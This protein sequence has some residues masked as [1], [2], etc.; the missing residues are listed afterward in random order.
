MSQYYISLSLFVILLCFFL[1]LNSLSTFEPVKM[2]NV[3]SSVQF[4]FAGKTEGEMD[5]PSV[6][7]TPSQNFG[8][9][10]AL[11]PLKALFNT[12]IKGFKASTNRMGTEMMVR[13]PVAEFERHIGLA[14][15]AGIAR[16]STLDGRG[17][18]FL[19]TLVS[20]LNTAQTEIPYRMDILLN[21]PSDPSVLNIGEP[22]AFRA[23]LG[24]VSAYS[25]A[26]EKAGLPRKL[27]SSG[28]AEGVPA[29]RFE[30]QGDSY[31]ELYFRPY[32]PIDPL[33]GQPLT[34]KKEA[35]DE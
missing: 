32:I 23:A 1:V 33:A 28:L 26:L 3:L 29:N 9:G 14:A 8:K 10:D 27:V 20:L 31:I 6:R 19:S 12:E 18:A 22:E 2:H 21:L 15:D 4:A 13:L 34:M 24:Q 30:G 7:V 35:A 17:G 11:A 25:E 5:L 16:R